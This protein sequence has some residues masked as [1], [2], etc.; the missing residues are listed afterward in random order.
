[1]Q[2]VRVLAG[3][4][5][6]ILLLVCAHPLLAN[7]APVPPEIPVALLVDVNT[8]QR[9]FAREENRRL[10]PASVVKVM[11]AYT[12]FRLVTE[13]RISTSTRVPITPELEKEWSGVGSTMFLKAGEAPTFGELIL[14]ATTVSGNDASVAIAQAAAGSLDEWLALMNENAAALG[15]R[16]THF[17]SANG[18]P[19]EGRTFT[20]AHDLALLGSAIVTR[21]PDLYRRYF[22]H[23]TLRWRNIEQRNHDPVTGRVA[24][25]DGMKTG[26]TSE[27]GYTFLG[28]AERGGRRLVMV[29]AGAPTSQLRDETA[30]GLLEWGFSGFATRL[31][32]PAR[33][34]LGEARVQD[35]SARKVALVAARDV[36]L[37]IP[38]DAAAEPVYTITYRGPLAAPIRAGQEVARLHV[39]LGDDEVLDLPLL[40]AEDVTQ[41]GFFRRI[42]NGI[43]GVFG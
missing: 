32:A 33:T 11:T 26:F 14:G 22:G 37:A 25:A 13:G 9:L 7:P 42:I 19:D 5:G 29:I 3:K 6:A 36:R 10:M 34:P 12:A 18:Y 30:R 39:R 23:R 41:A 8:G 16:N 40:A 15:M 28:S 21:Y 35:G 1:M 2:I 27:A 24:G 31:V 43:V 38:H 20:T 17:G 4:V